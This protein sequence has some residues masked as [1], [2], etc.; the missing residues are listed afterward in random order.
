MQRCLPQ[1]AS[2]MEEAVAVASRQLSSPRLVDRALVGFVAAAVVAGMQW[3][4]PQ[5]V[6]WMQA[7]VVV[8]GRRQGLP[9]LVD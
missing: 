3:R 5:P 4:W 1:P 6:G 7:A 8:A 2:W 9:R